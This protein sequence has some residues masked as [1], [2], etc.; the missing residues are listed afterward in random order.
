MKS[1]FI[2]LKPDCVERKLVGKIISRFERKGLEMIC[3]KKISPTKEV[4]E[5]HYSE[6]KNKDF[7]DGL[8]TFMLTGP[9]VCMVWSG[10]DIIDVARNMIDTIRNDFSSTRPQNI[11]HA[12][13]SKISAEREIYLWFKIHSFPTSF[14]SS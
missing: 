8:I 10:E 9:V 13:D 4:L 5:E 11:I 1:T 14:A 2:M 12:S 6:H 3:I 7:F